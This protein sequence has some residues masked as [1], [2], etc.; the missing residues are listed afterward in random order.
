M[1]TKGIVITVLALA[2]MTFRGPAGIPAEQQTKPAAPYQLYFNNGS[3]FIVSSSHQ[4]TAWMDTPAACR[5]FRVE[6]NIMPALEMMRNNPDY[7]GCTR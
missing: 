5:Q 7:T 1:R 6:H 2:G 4:D 3:V